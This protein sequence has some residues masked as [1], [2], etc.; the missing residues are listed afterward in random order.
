MPTISISTASLFMEN[1]LQQVGVPD[2]NAA[3]I[4]EVVLDSELRGHPDHGLFFF[5]SVV[6][7]HK[8][9]DAI[10]PKPKTRITKDAKL[11]TVID[12]DQGCGVIG[13]NWAMDLSVPKAKDLGMAA[14]SITNSANVIALAPFVQRAADEGLIAFA[15]SG[16]RYPLMP[17][18]GGTSSRFGTNPIDYAAPTG[19]HPPFL[20]DFSTAA[21][22]VAK[23]LE[24]AK[25]RD[26]ISAGL[27]EYADDRPLTDTSDFKLGSSLILPMA[28]VKGYGL[29][30]MVDMFAN[31]VGDSDWGISSGFST[32]LNSSQ[33]TGFAV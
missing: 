17:P 25:Y 31:V 12:G 24:A 32:H 26:P 14:A 8:P 20:L 33:S 18:V 6:N 27:V 16:F 19:K 23:V 13:M 15:C 4:A 22:A 3:Q 5:R 9:Y 1:A 7:W 10:N 29:A 2:T 11:F 30:M 21:I 28:G